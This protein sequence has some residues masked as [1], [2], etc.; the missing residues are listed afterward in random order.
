MQG[1]L[2]TADSWDEIARGIEV[3]PSRLKATIK[4]Y[5]SDCD[6]GRDHLFAKGIE[7][8]KPLRHPPFYAIRGRLGHLSTLGGIKINY[9]MEVLNKEDK[10][11]KGLYAGGN[12]AGGFSGSTYNV[13]LA[14]TGS[15]FALNSGRIAGENATKYAL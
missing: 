5:N 6:R 13:H 9:R 2:K 7:H 14:G 15:G 4:E 3:N 12:D 10:P 1:R 8:L 11:I